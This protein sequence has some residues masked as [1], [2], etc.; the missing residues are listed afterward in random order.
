MRV[1]TAK[2][3][4]FSIQWAS[5]D[6]HTIKYIWIYGHMDEITHSD[7]TVKMLCSFFFAFI[8]SFVRS[9]YRGSQILF[10]I[11]RRSPI[12]KESNLEISDVCFRGNILE[13]NSSYCLNCSTK[14]PHMWSYW[15]FSSFIS[16]M[17]I[18]KIIPDVQYLGIIKRDV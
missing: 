13:T 10:P 14:K 9:S 12:N 1:T 3:T 17:T 11:I 8:F 4:S 15:M 7:N 18:Q 2:L 16:C 5:D 6:V